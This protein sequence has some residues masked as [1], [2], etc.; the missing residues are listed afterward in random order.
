M[1]ERFVEVYRRRGL[2]V[3]AD[4]RKVTVVRGEDGLESEVGVGGNAIGACGGAIRSLVNVRG[5]QLQYARILHKIFVVPVLVYCSETMIWKEKMSRIRIVQ[6][7]NL[8]GF[9]CIRRM[10]KV[11]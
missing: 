7:D 6:I 3:N 11:P 10:D 5:L 2:K 4:K 1:G 9:L 8:K